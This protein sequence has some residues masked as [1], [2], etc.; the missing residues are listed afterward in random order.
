LSILKPAWHVFLKPAWHVFSLSSLGNAALPQ[1]GASSLGR[2][3]KRVFATPNVSYPGVNSTAFGR[4]LNNRIGG[5][6][7]HH[8]FIQQK[9]FRDG[10]A[11]NLFPNNDAAR[12]GL[13]RLGNAGF[14]LL[15]ILG[16]LNNTL[17][18]SPGLTGALGGTLIGDPFRIY[19]NAFNLSNGD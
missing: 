9:A 19:M 11:S 15:P 1:Y 13:Q 5:F 6:Q 12:I 17:G 18:R 8:V 3:I 7:Q 10:G 4:F 14:N 16:S 2:N